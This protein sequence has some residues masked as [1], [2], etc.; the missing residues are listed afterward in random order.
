MAESYRVGEGV[1]V[2]GFLKRCNEGDGLIE[3]AMGRDP[4]APFGPTE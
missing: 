3:P 1:D 2:D 4:K